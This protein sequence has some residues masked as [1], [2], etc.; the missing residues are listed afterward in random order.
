MTNLQLCSP[1]LPTTWEK[2]TVRCNSNKWCLDNLSHSNKLHLNK[3][4]RNN[5]S[6][7][8]TN[9]TRWHNLSRCK[10]HVRSAWNRWLAGSP[11]Q[12][13]AVTSSASNASRPLY[14]LQKSAP[15][16]R[17]IWNQATSTTFSSDNPAV[18]LL[19]Q[20]IFC[21]SFFHRVKNSFERGVNESETPRDV[22]MTNLAPD[23]IPSLNFF[24]YVNSNE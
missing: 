21:F 7:C 23:Y 5:H 13:F 2:G 6:R 17:R 16:A 24:N 4:C 20:I 9:K 15:C 1:P 22:T 8:H 14:E 19:H 3:R 18:Q 10:F 12:Q 11:Y